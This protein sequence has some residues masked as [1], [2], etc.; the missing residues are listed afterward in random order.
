[1]LVPSSHAMYRESYAQNTMP[2]L[3][4]SHQTSNHKR[5]TGRRRHPMETHMDA[6]LGI[7]AATEKQAYLQEESCQPEDK[8]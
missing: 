1:M 4:G 3:Q 2:E 6:C 7:A 5:S 8:R